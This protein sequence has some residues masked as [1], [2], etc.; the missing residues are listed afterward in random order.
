MF[1]FFAHVN[2][3]DMITFKQW[4]TI[5][6]WAKTSVQFGFEVFALFTFLSE[7]FAGTYKGSE[8][9]FHFIRY[10]WNEFCVFISPSLWRRDIKH[11]TSVINTVWNQ[12]LLQILF[13]T[14][15][16]RKN[17]RKTGGGGLP[18]LLRKTRQRRDVSYD[19]IDELRRFSL[20]KCFPALCH[21][22]IYEIAIFHSIK[23]RNMW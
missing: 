20:S 19:V 5:K 18:I 22:L 7:W 3:S 14:C 10:L 16:T 4:R 23:R 9:N 2:Y 21:K 13:I 6:K 1:N 17:V 12:N 8:I 11:T 15:L